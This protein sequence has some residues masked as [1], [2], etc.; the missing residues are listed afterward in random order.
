[1]TK[2]SICVSRFRFITRLSGFASRA[3]L[4]LCC[5]HLPFSFYA[6]AQV[7]AVPS[8]AV[9]ELRKSYAIGKQFRGEERI[10]FLVALTMT[11][12]N[13][14]PDS[15]MRWCEELFIEAS[16]SPLNWDHVS[17]Q[18]Q[19]AAALAAVDPDGALMMLGAV[20]RP[21]ALSGQFPEDVRAQA[22]S[23]I[24]PLF[25]RVHGMNKLAQLQMEAQSIGDSGEY[26]YRAMAGIIDQ[27]MDL[28]SNDARV[29]AEAILIDSL[30]YYERGSKFSNED[31][32]FLDVLGSARRIGAAD[33][34]REAL[35]HFL[36]R[37]SGPSSGEETFAALVK[38]SH[39]IVSVD[40][41]HRLL[42]WRVMPLVKD[43]DPSWFEKLVAE[44]P[45]LKVAGDGVETLGSSSIERQHPAAEMAEREQVLLEKALVRRIE[46]LSQ[47][48]PKHALEM[49]SLL[50]GYSTRIIAI[51]SLL[52][53][54][55]K[56]D[57]VTAKQLYD[58][59]L[60]YLQQV[61]DARDRL[62]A[63]VAVSK[64][65]FL[66]HDLA[67]AR[68]RTSEALVVGEI[69]FDQDSE[70]GNTQSREGYR[71]TGDL[72]EFSAEHNQSWVLEKVD[73]MKSPVLKAHLL[74][75]AAR[76]MAQ[77]LGSQR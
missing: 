27:L 76:G 53:G 63:L 46:S 55:I 74:I 51:A 50:T 19:A 61:G 41:P 75:F 2:V 39:G 58:H 45:E 38:T 29:Q 23:E 18:K 54:L 15:T 44:K 31:S 14:D 8:P 1:M 57:P 71:E 68:A 28:K 77:A 73:H 36:A 3:G 7:V 17:N 59:Q 30:R 32:E 47:T 60:Q 11:S 6:G 40:D 12:A 67:I 20:S 56:S 34:Y 64:S 52:P 16:R 35:Q 24:F 10:S 70:K 25:W 22:A 49:T 5:L 72:V 69:L 42:L 33:S 9:Q 62:P 13:I 21:Q 48:D 43:F 37:V 4:V 66:M 26:P 65:A